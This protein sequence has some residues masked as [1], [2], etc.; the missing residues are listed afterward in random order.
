MNFKRLDAIMEHLPKIGYPCGDL[1]VTKDGEVIYHKSVGFSDAAKTKPIDGSEL[2]WIYS[3]SKVITCIAGMRLV[4]RG[5]ISLDDPVSKYIPE[6]GNMMI[7]NA[8][9]TLTPAKEPMR[10]EHLFTMSGGMDYEHEAPE[11][12]NATDRS[13]LGILRAMAKRPLLFE[14]GTRYEYSFCHD[15]LAGVIEVASGMKFS[16]YV[17]EHIFRPLGI[18]DM[19]FRPNEEQKARFAAM[20]K[21]HSGAMQAE[22]KKI[23]NILQLSPE[24]DSGG[25]GLF[26]GVN[27]YIKIITTI[28]C[29]GTTK[30]GYVLLRPE[31]IES[32]KQ[33]RLTDR[34]RDDFD[35]YGYGWGYGFG[36]CC[37]THMR[38][39]VSFSL[40][41][42]GEM[43]WDGA[44]GA[45]VMIDTDNRIAMYF[46]THI[47]GFPYNARTI[48]PKF[49]NFLYEDLADNGV[50]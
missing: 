36:L 6:Y 9:G 24:Y 38:P 11:I 44:A 39:D 3:A 40:S 29:G 45:F 43:G 10:V 46:G 21:F 18:K 48:H 15:V 27:E 47:M 14:P 26:A 7:Q 35:R 31:T 4:E 17:I 12:V 22:E 2:Y 33:N 1:V 16:D 50:L 41:P 5:M 8:D 42:V 19:G 25:A 28:A 20:Y 23:E 30:D 49:R 13:T 37:R 34:A 32:M